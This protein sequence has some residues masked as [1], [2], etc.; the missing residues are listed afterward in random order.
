[1]PTRSIF[2]IS[3][4]PEC[5][6]D[7][8]LY[9]SFRWPIVYDLWVR[10]LYHIRFDTQR[11]AGYVKV[12]VDDDRDQV[13]TP[14]A[15]PAI[16]N[17]IW[18]VYPDAPNRVYSHTQKHPTDHSAACPADDV[19]SHFREGIYRDPDVTGTSVIFQDSAGFA[20]TREEAEAAVGW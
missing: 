17:P 20:S 18:T 12:W 3:G 7:N 16:P 15:I 4:G 5:N 6:S 8:N 2:R 9:S 19:C 14:R 11:G 1:M 10:I 13:F